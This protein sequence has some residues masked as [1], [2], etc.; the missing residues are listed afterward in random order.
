MSDHRP[1]TVLWI[2]RPTEPEMREAFAYCQRHAAQ[3]ALRE[4][5]P[6]AL[7]HPAEAVTHVILA[8]DR[9]RLVPQTLLDTFAQ[10][11]PDAQRILIEGSGAQGEQR[12]GQPWP[13]WQRTAWHAW[14]QILPESFQ[15][16]PQAIAAV[17]GLTLVVAATE[18][19]AAALLDVLDGCGAAALWQPTASARR[20]R[21]VGRVLWDDSAAPACSPRCWRERLDGLATAEP[22]RHAWLVN[23]PRLE[24]IDA[25]HR[26]GLDVVLSKPYRRDAI[27]RFLCDQ[28]VPSSSTFLSV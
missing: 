23:Y 15:P 10:R 5:L 17:S 21:Q 25:A 16:L 18:S 8:R 3:V 20:L 1:R 11:Y 27:L 12:T 14:N 9:R 13:D 26:G 19:Q 4:D 2:G 6:A 7:D 22:H 28:S 24:Q